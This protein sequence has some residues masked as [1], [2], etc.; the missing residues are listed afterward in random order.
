M[1]K[2][3]AIKPLRETDLYE[4]VRD[5]LTAQG[6]EVRGEVLGCD[7]TAVKEGALIVVELKRQFSIDLLAQAAQRQKITDS[8]YV[9]V[10]RPERM[11]WRKW[12]ALQHLLKRLEL[13]LL[14]VV[15]GKRS[16]RVELVFHP[17]PFARRKQPV[18]RRAVI[19]EIAGRSGDHNRG[20]SHGRKLM[21]AYREQALY[22]AWLL[23]RLGAQRPRDLRKLGG[24][25]KTQSILYS[26]VYGWF[27]RVGEGLYAINGQGKAA[28]QEYEK[29]TA[30]FELPALPDPAD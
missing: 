10:P 13:G 15:F 29:I 11:P 12:Q 2:K 27:D 5:Y 1:K 25:E 7:I 26:N 18:K 23:E 14:L 30:Q 16:S 28:L 21:T 6:Y 3:S 20:G 4:P 19:Q 24:S 8:V 9:A 22:L 17:A